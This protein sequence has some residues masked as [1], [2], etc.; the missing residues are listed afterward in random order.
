MLAIAVDRYRL[1]VHP[2][3]SRIPDTKA[4]VILALSVVVP[5]GWWLDACGG[6][7]GGGVVA[8]VG[9]GGWWGWWGGWMEGLRGCLQVGGGVVVELAS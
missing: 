9:G 3:T 7:V 2:L 8:Q 6:E 1:I 5:T 4:Y